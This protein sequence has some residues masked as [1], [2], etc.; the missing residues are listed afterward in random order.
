MFE[1]ALNKSTVLLSA[2]GLE[3]QILTTEAVRE[4]RRTAAPPL[5]S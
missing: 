4:T 5:G 2:N 1:I 3:E